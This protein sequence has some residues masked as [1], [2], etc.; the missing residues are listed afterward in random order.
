[1]EL[2]HKPLLVQPDPRPTVPNARGSRL[3]HVRMIENRNDL[4]GSL[5]QTQANE[6][7]Q[8]DEARLGPHDGGRWVQETTRAGLNIVYFARIGEDRPI[9]IG[10]SDDVDRRPIQ[11]ERHC[12]QPL[13]LSYVMDGVPDG[14]RG[15]HERFAPLRL[16]MTEQFRPGAD[17]MEFVGKP[18]PVR[19]DP[20]A[21]EV[22]KPG[23]PDLTTSRSRWIGRSRRKSTTMRKKESLVGGIAD[24]SLATGDRRALRSR[25]QSGGSNEVL[26]PQRCGRTDQLA[27]PV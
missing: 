15:I 21:V 5:C 6:C 11:L 10:I 12:R 25:D 20:I 1:M 2:I 27:E 7:V 23:S 3:V 4:V 26:C 24:R 18:L 9:K 22:L 8:L 17:L 14:E 19:P 16:G 13:A